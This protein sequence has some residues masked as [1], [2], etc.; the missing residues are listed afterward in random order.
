L[1]DARWAQEATQGA[2]EAFHPADPPAGEQVYETGTVLRVG[3]NT[4]M[5]FS[6]QQDSSQA[7]TGKAMV[8]A[9]KDVRPAGLS[10]PLEYRQQTVAIA[11]GTHL[12]TAV[13]N[14]KVTTK[15]YMAPLLRI[16]CKI[17]RVYPLK[18][19]A[20]VFPNWDRA[21]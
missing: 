10:C 11:Q 1:I 8:S 6:Q 15:E 7:A 5:A 3:V 19:L 9:G 16:R 12:T 13:A 18:G 4:G 20:L 17:I 14:Q 2:L 21:R